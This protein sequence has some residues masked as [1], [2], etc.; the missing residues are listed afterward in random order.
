MN[1]GFKPLTEFTSLHGLHLI[2]QVYRRVPES[3]LMPAVH[4]WL[5]QGI[6]HPEGTDFVAKIV[7]ELKRQWPRFAP[8]V[9][10]RFVEN[11][12]GHLMLLSGATATSGGIDNSASVAGPPSPL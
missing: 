6:R 3:V 12:F 11:L 10:R 7:H 5:S 8:N 9:R 2:E 1:I 4:W